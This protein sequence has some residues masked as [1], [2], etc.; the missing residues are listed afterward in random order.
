MICINCDRECVDGYFQSPVTGAKSQ[1]F[2]CKECYEANVGK[3]QRE[4]SR[5]LLKSFEKKVGQ[6]GGSRKR[7]G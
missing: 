4:T 7:L 2:W 3:S 5:M 1:S 6:N